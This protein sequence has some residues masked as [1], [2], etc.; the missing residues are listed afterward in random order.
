VIATKTLKKRAL[1][2][3]AMASLEAIKTQITNGKAAMPSFKSRLTVDEI[4][5]VA[6]YVLDQADNGW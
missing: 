3:Y 2:T 1:E 5:D 6:A 4:E